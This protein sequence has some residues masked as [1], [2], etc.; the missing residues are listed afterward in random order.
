M[1]WQLATFHSLT[2]LLVQRFI[3]ATH[4]KKKKKIPL[5]PSTQIST[6]VIHSFDISFSYQSIQ[7]TQPCCPVPNPTL[8]FPQRIC[9]CTITVSNGWLLAFP[10]LS[11]FYIFLARLFTLSPPLF[12]VTSIT[13][14][15]SICP[16]RLSSPPI[17]SSGKRKG[18]RNETDDNERQRRSRR[19]LPLIL[20][21][22]FFDF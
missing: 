18:K 2:F 4:K 13:T 10:P 12:T 1:A 21:F 15:C 9:I 20:F 22:D 3:Y 5:T 8:P 16:V 11:R 17:H 19:L 14:E 7:T 6:Q